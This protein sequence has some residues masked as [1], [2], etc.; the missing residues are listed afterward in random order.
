M[1][2]YY[3]KTLK[4]LLSYLKILLLF[5]CTVHNFLYKLLYS[6]D[7]NSV[8][9]HQK[10]LSYAW[11]HVPSKLHWIRGDSHRS[12]FCFGGNRSSKLAV[13]SD[14]R[15]AQT[16]RLSGCRSCIPHSLLRFIQDLVHPSAHSKQFRRD[17]PHSLRYYHP[18]F[19]LTSLSSNC[20]IAAI[21]SLFIRYVR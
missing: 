19:S 4:F 6:V 18:H 15:T 21:L 9:W 1:W 13:R 7:L 10:G 14:D 11:R 3:F 20:L 17:M 2:F 16:D 5:P 8:F 12:F